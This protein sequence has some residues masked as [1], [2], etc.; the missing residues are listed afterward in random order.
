MPIARRGLPALGEGLRV[1]RGR[2]SGHV[3]RIPLRSEGRVSGRDRPRNNAGVTVSVMTNSCGAACPLGRTPPVFA[4]SSGTPTARRCWLECTTTSL[5]VA[6]AKALV[7]PEAATMMGPPNDLG[8]GSTPTATSSPVSPTPA[9]VLQSVQLLA[10]SSRTV[11]RVAVTS[12][13]VSTRPASRRRPSRRATSPAPDPE[14]WA[15]T[16]ERESGSWTDSSS[17]LATP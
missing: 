12:P 8:K 16:A 14:R 17:W 10:G 5:R 7:I 9:V 1:A 13:R 4:F 2:D 3:S 6:T 11:L 15:E